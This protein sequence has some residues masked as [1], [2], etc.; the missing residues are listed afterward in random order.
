MIY[1]SKKLENV[2]L[3]NE[4]EIILEDLLVTENYN[5][6]FGNYE[7][8]EESF[9]VSKNAVSVLI[10]NRIRDGV[11]GQPIPHEECTVKLVKDS[12]PKYEDMKGLPFTISDPVKLYKD[13]DNDRNRKAV[14][15]KDLNFLK[16]V[17]ENHYLEIKRYW[18]A[19]P[20]TLKGQQ[21]LKK[22]EREMIKKY[23]EG[24]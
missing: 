1:T 6:I 7:S 13:A 24:K 4:E 20:N 16:E 18:D 17:I 12:Y 15:K 23:K 10:R 22:V 19:D 9:S 21:T 3:E 8:I 11:N 14:S 5:I 2:M